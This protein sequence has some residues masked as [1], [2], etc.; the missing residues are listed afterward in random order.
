MDKD[1]TGPYV[2]ANRR[3]EQCLPLALEGFQGMEQ[4]HHLNQPG[5]QQPEWTHWP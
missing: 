3:I 1:C 4:E 2:E 5:H